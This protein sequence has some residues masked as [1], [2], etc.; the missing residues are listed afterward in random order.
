MNLLLFAITGLWPHRQYVD[1]LVYAD[2]QYVGNPSDLMV[3]KALSYLTGMTSLTWSLYFKDPVGFGNALGE[4]GWDLVIVDH[5][6][7]P[8]IGAYWDDLEAW[9]QRGGAL[10]VS[11]YDT[12]GSH[13]GWTT[14]WSAMGAVASGNIDDLPTLSIWDGVLVYPEQPP[15]QVSF[16]ND[17]QDEGDSLAIASG[18]IAAA[19][20]GYQ[21]LEDYPN[22]SVVTK[23]C[24]DRPRTLLNSFILQ[25]A[26]GDDDHDGLE[27]G[28]EIYID[29]IWYV[30]GCGGLNLD[31]REPKPGPPVKVYPNPFS[32]SLHIIAPPGAEIS[33]WD[34][35]GRMAISV[36][37]EGF[38]NLE[39]EDLRPGAYILMAVSCEGTTKR[40][41]LKR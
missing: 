18:Y 17:Y 6:S 33:L 37:S 12:D 3:V 20:W 13:T 14:L 19:G 36:V 16:S 10:I 23:P 8:G 2:A 38:V 40:V 1:I 32:E 22:A 5:A 21:Y 34:A 11:T 28:T 26:G 29:E 7:M 39:T 35:G 24:E 25:E 9:V 31:E 4:G 15:H 41:I 30:L 27:D